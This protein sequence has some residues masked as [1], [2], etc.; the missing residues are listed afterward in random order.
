MPKRI[1]TYLLIVICALLAA[2]NDMNELYRP[3][4]SQMP[5]SGQNT[6]KTALFPMFDSV[7]AI[8]PM[9]IIFHNEIYQKNPNVVRVVLTGDSGLMNSITYYV[10]D[11]VLTLFVNPYFTYD[12]NI[13][14]NVNIYSPALDRIYLQGAG[15]VNAVGLSQPH[16]R[17]ILDGSGYAFLAGRVERYEATLTGTARLN[18]K[19]LYSRM[20]FVNTTDQAQ[21]EILT[22]TDGVSAFA[23]GNSDIYY[24]SDPDMVAPYTRQS[25]S[26]MR[27][28]GLVQP[29]IQTPQTMV[30][31]AEPP[32]HKVVEGRG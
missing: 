3:K 11:G 32:A 7:S 5:M 23:S 19:C 29:S 1:T 10:K 14:V 24:Y 2:C 20:I 17:I 22:V 9:N 26:V 15:H 16:L 28:T 13:R 18:A 21:A 30:L 6:T 31:D 8:G 4:M 12:P 27:M 25:G